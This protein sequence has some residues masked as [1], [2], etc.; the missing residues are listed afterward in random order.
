MDVLNKRI[1]RN[2]SMG[3]CYLSSL[4]LGKVHQQHWL[5]CQALDAVDVVKQSPNQFEGVDTANE[6]SSY[7]WL[8]KLIFSAIT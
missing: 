4:L 5:D 3:C 6:D 2:L 1:L 8:C 7:T